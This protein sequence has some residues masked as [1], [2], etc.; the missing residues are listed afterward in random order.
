MLNP[1][2]GT[3]LVIYSH[4]V[5]QLHTWSL[6]IKAIRQTC[7]IVLENKCWD[8]LVCKK[9]K[10]KNDLIALSLTSRPV[11]TQMQKHFSPVGGSKEFSYI[12]YNE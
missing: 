11:A 5:L 10:N 3:T 2:P 1:T 12:R 7:Q 6:T 9:N 8:V 4:T